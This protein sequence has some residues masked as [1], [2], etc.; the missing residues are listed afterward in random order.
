LDLFSSDKFIEQGHGT[1]NKK[2]SKSI[3][4][5]TPFVEE[6]HQEASSPKQSKETPHAVKCDAQIAKH[7]QTN[8]RLK[9]MALLR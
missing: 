8:A 6:S 7:E 9:E 2:Q 1:L 3:T 5:A 4:T